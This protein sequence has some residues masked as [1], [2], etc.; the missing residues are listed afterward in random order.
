MHENVFSDETFPKCSLN[1]T[2]NRFFM[3]VEAQ[4]RTVIIMPALETLEITDV[5]I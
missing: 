2:Y 1:G 3:G 4:R 5:D